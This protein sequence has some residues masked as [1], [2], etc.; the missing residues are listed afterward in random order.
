M[1]CTLIVF[2][3]NYNNRNLSSKSFKTFDEINLNMNNNTNKNMKV[4]FKDLAT[5]K[6]SLISKSNFSDKEENYYSLYD[7]SQDNCLIYENE[8]DD[9]NVFYKNKINSI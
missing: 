5:S 7:K 3:N 6:D 2:K 8:N 9:E 4:Y 1:T